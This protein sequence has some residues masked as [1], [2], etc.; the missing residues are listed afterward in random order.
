MN[1]IDHLDKLK[2]F[3][4]VAQRGSIN[5]ASQELA[6]TQPAIT[7]AI[8][9][10]EKAA[11]YPLFIRTR[12]GMHLTPG[13][14]ILF[15]ASIRALKEVTDATSQGANAQTAMAGQLTIGT[16]ESLAEYLWPE[17]LMKAQKQFPLLSL[18]LKTNSQEG[19]RQ[20][21]A[22]GSLDLLV[23]AEPRAHTG[24]TA[25]PLYADRFAFYSRQLIE[26]NPA[27]THQHSLIYVKG[28]FDEKNTSLEQYLAQEGYKFEREYTF[29]SFT[30]V[31][32]A[33]ERGLGVA[34]LPRQLAEKEGSLKMVKA[35]G[36]AKEGF[37]AHRIYAT[38]SNFRENDIRVKS[39]I[40]LLRK[41][42]A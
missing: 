13:G 22:A 6:L 25:W 42:L 4:L 7:R 26:L 19:H 3:S 2:V 30:T 21:L 20:E 34:I 16:F 8:Q 24:L 15:S 1:I 41:H 23:D 11:G 12:S 18:S 28:V 31:K 10:L 27:N 14:S 40:S 29:D 17:F 35:K 39:L 33:A 36:F 37:G 9:T 38:V 32:R 5:G